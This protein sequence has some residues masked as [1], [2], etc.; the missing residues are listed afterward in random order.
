MIYDFDVLKEAFVEQLT[1][2]CYSFHCSTPECKT[3][4][5]FLFRNKPAE[6]IEQLAEGYSYQVMELQNIKDAY[7]FICPGLSPIL[8][9]LTIYENIIEFNTF[10]SEYSKQQK[11]S[12]PNI[13]SALFSSKNTFIYF[14]CDDVGIL[15]PDTITFSQEATENYILGFNTNPKI[16]MKSSFSTNF[17]KTF[18]QLLSESSTSSMPHIRGLLVCLLFLP[19]INSND[20][21]INYFIHINQ[22]DHLSSKLYFNTLTSNLHIVKFVLPIIHRVLNNIP[23]RYL[24]Q[25]ILK[26]PKVKE[27]LDFLF[28]LSDANDIGRSNNEDSSI[29]PQL[30]MNDHLSSSIS[31]NF[32][33]HQFIEKKPSYL[34]YPMV[35]TTSFKAE[36]RKYE[37]EKLIDDSSQ[38]TLMGALLNGQIPYLQD[39]IF[40]LRVRRSSLLSDTI[41]CLLRANPEDLRKRLKVEFE[42]E[43]AIDAGG[44]S[45]DF[46]TLVTNALFSPD[47][48][49]FVLINNQFYWFMCH[50]HDFDEYEQYYR[51][52]GLFVGMAITNSVILPIRFPLVLYRKLLNQ[53]MTLHDY[54]EIDPQ[55]AETL[56]K[57]I[58]TAHSPDQEKRDEIAS[59]ELYFEISENIL[60]SVETI[61]LCPN[62][63]NKLVTADNADEY[64]K[65]YIDWKLNKSVE[66]P[67]ET[68]RASFD[69]FLQTPVMRLFQ[70]EELDELISG[71]EEMDWEALK[72]VV[73]Y[74]DGYTSRSKSVKIFWKIFDHWNYEQKLQMLYFITGS[75]KAPAG[76]LKNLSLKISKMPK[77][78]MLPIAHTCFNTL[79]LP[80]YQDQTIMEHN[81]EICLENSESFGII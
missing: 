61:Q 79:V 48:A 54:A 25:G 60:G 17:Q 18:Q 6:K 21:L 1:N 39:I 11:I 28:I 30:F 12:H 49:M 7:N 62:G 34:Q 65:L 75:K 69:S 44:V 26:N 78:N 46:F 29:L 80:D 42:G 10:L 35:L 22:L 63:S 5:D 64:V 9:D 66:A 14:F 3:C 24:S 33:F 56:E 72:K 53:K 36:V 73:V 51:V 31:P 38:Q 70:P 58:I 45:R 40:N 50:I 52:F 37:A 41:R 8:Y 19:L 13:I 32:E 43:E 71:R 23:D 67:F 68:F 81:L 74:E 27:I 15:T 4:S 20:L 55:A 77:S 16:M 57:L 47:Y 76:G 2:G 59:Y